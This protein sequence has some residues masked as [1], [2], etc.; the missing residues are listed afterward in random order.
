MIRHNTHQLRSR[1]GKPFAVFVFAVGG[2]P[3]AMLGRHILKPLIFTRA[4]NTTRDFFANLR[5][6]GIATK[7]ERAEISLI[8]PEEF[9]FRWQGMV[10]A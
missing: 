3:C 2:Q 9:R 5:K 10:L 4:S 6:L 8:L 1:I 7:P